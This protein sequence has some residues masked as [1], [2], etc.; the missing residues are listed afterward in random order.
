M[1]K[2][3]LIITII[4]SLNFF[5][6][7]NSFWPDKDGDGDI[8]RCS[9]L[10]NTVDVEFPGKNENNNLEMIVVNFES[11]STDQFIIGEDSE[12][13]AMLVTVNP[14]K[15]A[16][17]ELSYNLWYTVLKWATAEERGNYVYKFGHP[18]SEGVCTDGSLGS[19]GMNFVYPNLGEAP[20]TNGM[21]VFGIS[22]RDAAVWC[23]AFSEMCGLRPVYYKDNKYIDVYRSSCYTVEDGGKRDSYDPYPTAC[24]SDYNTL[25]LGGIDNPYIDK[26]A[27]GFRLPYE[28]EWE[29]AARKCSDK[30]FISGRAVSGD[31]TGIVGGMTLLDKINGKTFIESKK[32]RDY[33]WDMHNSK[34]TYTGTKDSKLTAAG[35]DDSEVP[36]GTDL[37]KKRSHKQ[38]CKKP[39]D[40]GFYD[41]SGNVDEWCNNFTLPYG[42]SRN[43]YTLK[44]KRGGVAWLD[45]SG[46]VTANRGGAWPSR[47]DGGL[48]IAQN[49]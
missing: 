43:S 19:Y 23:N 41:M 40:L 9:V 24:S 7:K 46:T 34:G 8:L 21:P 45:E 47:G 26:S 12:D 30:T 20:S 37:N 39:N 3:F 32:Y 16:K 1:K 5:S 28:Y 25:I 11:G 29:Y 6:C 18:G 13:S 44:A 49:Y 10:L 22:W 36:T 2:T 42:S 48:R 38:G 15:L 27:N 35:W 14:F 31:K 4:L 17:Y 33:E